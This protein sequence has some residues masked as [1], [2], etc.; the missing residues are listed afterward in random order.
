MNVLYHHRTKSRD[1]QAVH[2]RELIAAM[3]RRGLGVEE[4]ALSK[5]DSGDM[6]SEGGL[7]GRL[8][9]LAPR[10]AYELAEHA[11]GWMVNR[12]LVQAGKDFTADVLY[13]RHALNNTAGIRAARKLGI[14]LLLEVN[15]PLTHERSAHETLVFQGW[16]Q[17]SERRVLA[18]AD[19]LLVVT[20]V[21]ADMLV[22]DGVDPAK[23]EVIP[24][25]ADLSQYPADA[26]DDHEGLV[27]GFSGFFRPWHDIESLVT[28]LADGVLPANARLLLVGDG[29]SRESIEGLA[30]KLGVGERVTI[31]GAVERSQIPGLV[32]SMDI[33]VQP[34]AT[35]WASPL[36]LFEY[37]AAGRAIVAPDQDNLR[38]V[39]EHQRTGLLFE[40]GAMAQAVARLA[41]DDA[42]REDMGHGARAHLEQRPYTWDG[43]AAR[44]EAIAAE[45]IRKAR[46]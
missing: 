38:E 33:C 10:G 24:N 12:R 20:Q 22:A 7:L 19:R 44:V 41:H 40:P 31:T 17:R 15:S 23:I 4:W 21:L 45:C 37:M 42:L 8:A 18:A 30:A 14:P 46:S 32:R 29:P 43:N 11:Y 28:A 16:S 3:G 35:A 34:A 6:G 36:K 25:G 39:L 5:G 13:E 1:G 26:L 9:A 2:I 27:V